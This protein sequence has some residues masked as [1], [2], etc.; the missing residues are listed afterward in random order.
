[1]S[2]MFKVN[3]SFIKH[4]HKESVWV[5]FSQ[6]RPSALTLLGVVHLDLQCHDQMTNYCERHTVPLRWSL[7]NAHGR[8]AVP[9]CGQ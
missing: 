8:E 5:T 7:L 4:L 6:G 9:T 3:S 2:G 1:M